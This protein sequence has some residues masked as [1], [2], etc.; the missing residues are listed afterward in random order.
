MMALLCEYFVMN[1]VFCR[2]HIWIFLLFI[3]VY[4]INNM[5]FVANGFLPY[6][7]YN[8]WKSFKGII[9]PI[10]GNILSILMF[11]FM[12]WVTRQKLIMTSKNGKSIYS[13]NSMNLCKILTEKEYDAL[14][15]YKFS[16]FSSGDAS[17]SG[18]NKKF[19]QDILR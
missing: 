12:D 1:N 5:I 6:G 14:E 11:Y 10:L 3:G 19:N 2:R 17:I 4:L 15:G 9:T 18:S 16:Q 7:E 13:I 8:D